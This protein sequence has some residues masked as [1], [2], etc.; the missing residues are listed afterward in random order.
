VEGSCEHGSE[1]SGSSTTLQVPLTGNECHR[2]SLSFSVLTSL[3]SDEYPGTDLTQPRVKF[4]VILVPKV[5]LPV[6]LRAKHTSG[7]HD[8]I[9]VIVRQFPVCWCGAASLM[10]RR[11]CLL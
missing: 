1:L 11:V 6:C 10:R 8:Q 2:Q 3:L 7:A 4:N 5:S 9:F